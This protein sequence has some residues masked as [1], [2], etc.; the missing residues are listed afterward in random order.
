MPN[1]LDFEYVLT[2]TGVRRD[3]RI[4]IDGHGVIQS[5]EQS[6]GRSYDGFMAVPGMTNAHSHA[7]QRALTGYGELKTGNDSFWSWREAMY[8][9]A[10]NIMPDDMTVIAGRAYSDMLLAGFTSVAE[11][12]YLH[13]WPDGKPTFAMSEAV[14]EAAQVTGIRLTMLPVLYQRGG[15]DNRT[16]LEQRRFIHKSLDE[17]LYLLS[18]LKRVAR[19]IAPHSLRAVDPDTLRVLVEGAEDILG[20]DFPIHIH[21]SEQ[22]REVDE[23]L[24][25]HARTPIWLLADSTDLD[26]RWN[27]IHATHAQQSELQLLAELG[28]VVV[29]C[30]LTE[31]YLGDGIFPAAKF[32]GMQGRCAIG[33]DSNTRI[34][35]L[36]ELRWLEY[37]QRLL[38]QG[39]AQLGSEFSMGGA[40]WSHTVAQGARALRQPVAGIEAGNHADIVVLNPGDSPLSGAAPENLLDAW[41]VGGDRSAISN[42]YVGGQLRVQEGELVA[43][44]ALLDRFS[45]T[46]TNLMR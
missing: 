7:F 31:A 22:Q 14:I 41:L 6:A 34:D 24:A 44:P 45:K 35:A 10:A 33:S 30:P 3:C 1:T 27:L 19:G 18:R 11:F 23:C 5:V 40:L 15:F 28:L 25:A 46:V 26:Q 32:M 12:H 36:S 21:I 13:H 9:L 29:L 8:R 42:V 43:P 38:N 4:R 37:G 39:R 17:Y 16:S 20:D 2:P